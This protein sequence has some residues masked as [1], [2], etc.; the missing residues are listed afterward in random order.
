MNSLLLALLLN[1]AAVHA[2]RQ[3]AGS[4]SAEKWLVSNPE[5]ALNATMISMGRVPGVTVQLVYGRNPDI[6][7]GS[8]PEDI[9]NAGGLY[10]GFPIFADGGYQAETLQA[11]SS[12]GLDTA[13]GG[14][15][16]MRVQLEGLDSAGEARTESVFLN[17]STPVTTVGVFGRMAKAYVLEA[18][19]GG[20]NAGTITVRHSTTTTNVFAVMPIGYNQTTICG[21]SIPAGH[22][23]YVKL[24]STQLNAGASGAV[25]SALW[26]RRPGLPG[27]F[28]RSYD[29]TDAYSITDFIHGGLPVPE[30]SDVILRVLA[31]VTNNVKVNCSFDVVLVEN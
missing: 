1:Q 3:G 10:T 31:S 8:V 16:A 13:D 21:T 27:R 25:S 14:T 6:D 26:I 15:G 5:G 2:V 23:G 9:W 17:G 11:F 30:K 24:L 19:D 29:Q 12:S 18:G 28:E 22:T 7:T 4:T 20:V